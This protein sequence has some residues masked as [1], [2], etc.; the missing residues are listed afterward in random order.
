MSHKDYLTSTFLN[1]QF[2]VHN[3]FF[4]SS[5]D[6]C[7][8]IT[9]NEEHK[10]H[11]SSSE[12][13]SIL[14]NILLWSYLMCQGPHSLSL[15]WR[16]MLTSH[17]ILRAIWVNMHTAL[18]IHSK[19]L[20]IL[21]SNFIT[22]FSPY[23]QNIFLLYGCDSHSTTSS[24]LCQVYLFISV[25]CSSLLSIMDF[26]GLPQLLSN[27]SFHYV[28]HTPSTWAW[29]KSLAHT[30]LSLYCWIIPSPIFHLREK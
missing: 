20:V 11:Q 1:A 2:F 9:H 5:P 14:I 27:S 24:A 22:M 7:S 10:L 19:Y 12:P 25:K 8:T 17:N 30:R 18:R 3:S 26:L 13:R 23:T 29:T 16:T 21:T 4:P 6:I 15:K 28:Q